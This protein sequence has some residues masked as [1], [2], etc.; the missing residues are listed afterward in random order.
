MTSLAAA[1]ESDIGTRIA[2]AFGGRWPDD[3]VPVDMVIYSNAVGAYSTDGRVYRR[4]ERWAAQL[5]LLEQ[6]WRPV[7]ESASSDARSRQAASPRTLNSS[8]RQLS[9]CCLYV[10]ILPHHSPFSS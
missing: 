7:L 2:A 1:V 4:G 6:H 3:P 8:C 9:R 10:G 5:P